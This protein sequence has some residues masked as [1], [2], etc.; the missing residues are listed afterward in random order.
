MVM[1]Y[2]WY[3]PS[4]LW[5]FLNIFSCYSYVFPIVSWFFFVFL[6][7]IVIWFL[8]SFNSIPIMGFLKL[9]CMVLIDWTDFSLMHYL[10]LLQHINYAY[11]NLLVF[12]SYVLFLKLC[13]QSVGFTAVPLFVIAFVWFVGFGLCL[14]LICLCYFCC[15]TQPYGYSRMAY[16]LSLIL[17]VVFTIAAVYASLYVCVGFLSL[18]VS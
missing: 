1:N 6:V 14:S 7:D 17:L 5:T 16:A 10:L 12:I 2:G 9:V 3:P 11:H 13:L 18:L 4:W 8:S 15:A